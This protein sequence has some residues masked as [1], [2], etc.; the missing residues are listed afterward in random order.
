L[1]AKRL[2]R[3]EQMAGFFGNPGLFWTQLFG[4][5]VVAGFSFVVT[6][7]L[8]TLIDLVVG[9]RVTTNEELVG[10]DISQHAETV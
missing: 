5:V 1:P 4:A 9:L 8:A 7:V 6:Y 2:M 3:L 10:L